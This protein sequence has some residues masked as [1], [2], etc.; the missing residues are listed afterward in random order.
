VVSG[1]IIGVVSLFRWFAERREERRRRQEDHRA[2]RETREA[3]WRED[4]LK[5]DEDRLSAVIHEL[6]SPDELRRINAAHNLLTFLEPGYE[7]F[8]ARILALVVAHL[9]LQPEAKPESQPLRRLAKAPVMLIFHLILAHFRLEPKG[10]LLTP[11]MQALVTVFRGV[12]PKVRAMARPGPVW[13]EEVAPSDPHDTWLVVRQGSPLDMSAIQLPGAYLLQADLTGVWMPYAELRGATLSSA[14][15]SMATLSGAYLGAAQ[16]NGAT[17]IGP[18]SVMPISSIE[19]NSMG[20]PSLGPSFV[21]L[22]SPGP[23]S[24][25]L[26]SPRPISMEPLSPTLSFVGLI[27]PGPISAGSI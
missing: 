22:I 20:P 25:A 13:R 5:R 18:I 17:L 26:P 23:T 24:T 27:S 6:G 15:L 1:A 10:P 19:P 8:S 14:T 3:E 7:R 12:Y 21:G 9:R 11:F 16:L 2:E 4:R